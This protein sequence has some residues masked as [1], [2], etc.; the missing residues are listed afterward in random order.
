MSLGSGMLRRVV[1]VAM[2]SIATASLTLVMTAAAAPSWDRQANIVDAA[3]RLAKLH[4]VQGS[5]GVLK[6]LDACYRTHLLS[7]DFNQGVEGCLVQDYIHAQTLATIYSRLP[8]EARAERKL[9]APDVI[10]QAMQ[11]RLIA[12]FTQYKITPDDAVVFQK[13]I[14]KH[15]LPVFIKAVFPKA[16]PPNNGAS[17]NGA[18]KN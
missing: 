2:T 12:T 3:Q 11:R 9:P 14:E 18:N 6:F 4:R 1:L 15:G 13:L 7:S 17:K 5:Q 16:A 10:S 8:P